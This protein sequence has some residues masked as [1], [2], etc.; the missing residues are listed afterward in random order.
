MNDTLTKDGII[1]FLSSLAVKMRVAGP[2]RDA[3]VTE[4]RAAPPEAFSFGDGV[5]YKSPKE[6]YFPQTEK[7]ISFRGG[8]AIAE[9]APVPAA[10]FAARV[11]DLEALRVMREVFLSGRYKDPFFER[12]LEKNLIIGMACVSKKPGCFCDDLGF[13]MKF[14]DFCDMMLEPAGEDSFKVTGLSEKGAAALWEYAR[15]KIECDNSRRALT[16]K[17]ALRLNKQTRETEIFGMIDWEDMLS[18]CQGCGMC[19]YICPTCHC[20]EF[21]DV[22]E[23]EATSRYRCWD[24]CM[25]P[26]FTL[27]ASGH[28]PRAAT[29]ERYRQRALHKYLYVMQNT[30]MVAC[31]GCGRCVR[32]CPAGINI[33]KIVEAL[34]EAGA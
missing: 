8:K 9:E 15:V 7:M 28:N 25:Y 34:M 5:S 14:S 4:Y 6:F 23:G 31:T 18:A 10:V 26:R 27:H 29:S 1:A 13:D 19:T 32:S 33:K 2:V 17:P 24:S 21:K 12:R 30:G 20:F 16:S 22:S 3:K 11:C